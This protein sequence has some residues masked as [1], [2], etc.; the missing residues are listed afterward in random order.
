ME[1]RKRLF[2]IKLKTLVL[3]GILLGLFCYNVWAFNILIEE[4]KP[5]KEL[6]IANLEDT[7][8][9]DKVYAY[10]KQL[11]IKFPKTFIAQTLIESGYYKSDLFLD[12]SNCTGM[13]MGYLRPIHCNNISKICNEYAHYNHWRD[14]I[15]DYKLWQL[16]YCS[17]IKTEDEYLNYLGRIYAEGPQYKNKLIEISKELNLK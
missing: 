1:N 17:D 6:R 4:L 14:C 8:T 5:V 2:T 12:Y 10:A 16:S 15:V 11:K 3:G 9:V 7:I 13:K